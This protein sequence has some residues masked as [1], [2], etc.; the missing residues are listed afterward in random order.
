MVLSSNASSAKSKLRIGASSFMAKTPFRKPSHSDCNLSGQVI[1]ASGAV[2]AIC[3]DRLSG[4]SRLRAKST[5]LIAA[6][7][8]RITKAMCRMQVERNLGDLA[9]VQAINAAHFNG[10]AARLDTELFAYG[11]RH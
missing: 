8:H 5:G 9:G 1:A 4:S 11:M 7:R 3:L 2:K 10:H 6:K